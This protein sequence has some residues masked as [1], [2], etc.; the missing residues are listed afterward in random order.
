MPLNTIVGHSRQ[1]KLIK[2]LIERG[3]F[4]QSSIFSGVEGVGKKLVAVESLKLISGSD[5]EV[6]VIGS[7]KPAT[8]EE[9][10]E[11]TEWLFLRPTEG[12][13]KGVVIDNAEE[14]RSEASNALLKTLEEP[15]GYAYIILVTRNE[16]ALL[17]TIRSRCR[18]FRFGRLT[19]SNVEFIL[20]KQ[21]IKPDRKIIKLSGGSA[22]LALKLHES[23]VPQLIEE[24]S[25]LLKQRK[26]LPVL[27]EFTPKFSKVSREEARL[28]LDALENLVRERGTFDRWEEAINRG[29]LYLKFYGKPQS[30]VEWVI[31]TAILGKGIRAAGGSFLLSSF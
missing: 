1:I 10:R 22:G 27:S 9:V 23:Q 2:E 20:K 13:A 14:M 7:E 21:G 29:R 11:L 17:P 18:I 26:V 8:I 6:R 5:L 3:E 19:D 15:P 30:V 31:L 28:F 12:K 24:L 4:P 16:N 25:R